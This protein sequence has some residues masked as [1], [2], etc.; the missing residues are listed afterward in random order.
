[1]HP[2]LIERFKAK[3]DEESAFGIKKFLKTGSL[4]KGTVLRPRDSCGVDADIAV[5][6]TTI[7]ATEYDLNYLHEQLRKSLIAIYPT[8]RPDDFA[9]QPRTL[10][11]TFQT[12]GLDVDLVP[13]IPIEGPGD[14]GWQ[15]S[16]RGEPSLKTSVTGQLEFIRA[17]KN[18]CSRFTSLVR[19]LK[20]WRNYHELDDS[21]RSIII[22]RQSRR[23]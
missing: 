11:I 3:V 10:G 4:R 2:Y 18:R 20:H 22:L 14:Y 21:L 12:S 13:I 8:K 17:R 19:L 23:S 1:M 15:P 16:S 9:V 7:D 5:Y 6:L